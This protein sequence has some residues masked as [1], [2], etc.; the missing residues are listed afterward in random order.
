VSV[1]TYLAAE[2][3]QRTPL[4]AQ[5]DVLDEL[6]AQVGF[7]DFELGVLGV[8]GEGLGRAFAGL[9]GAGEEVEGQDFHIWLFFS[10]RSLEN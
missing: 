10:L 6:G 4:D 1:Q 9:A 3:P 2:A 8:Q 7:D 5:Q